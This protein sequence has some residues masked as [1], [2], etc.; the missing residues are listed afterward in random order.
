MGDACDP[1][2]TTPSEQIVRFETFVQMPSDVTL[3]FATYFPIVPAHDRFVVGATL[4][5]R[6][7]Q[8]THNVA[9]LMSMGMGGTRPRYYCELID[10][11][12]GAS[13]YSFTYTYDGASFMSP[14][15]DPLPLEPMG[16]ITLTTDNA[17]PAVHCVLG[18]DQDY[19]ADDPIPSGIAPDNV[20]LYVGDEVVTFRYFA[21]IRTTP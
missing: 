9:V 13:E 16:D 21:Q 5:A 11:Q 2:P 1:N 19:V 6:G 14:T 12:A 15:N 7:T 20:E 18:Y 4:G 8:T 10:H 3:G 17:P